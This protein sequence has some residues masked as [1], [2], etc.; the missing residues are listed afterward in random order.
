MNFHMNINGDTAKTI[1]NQLDDV[2]T[3]S[4]ALERALRK[5]GENTLH[6]RNYANAQDRSVD[7]L[8][9]QER[10]KGVTDTRLWAMHG[11]ARL[12][13][14]PAMCPEIRDN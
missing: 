14:N 13:N 6:G 10:L 5:L 2:I 7:V 3:A 12:I 1:R 8:A 9:H 11:I 4:Q